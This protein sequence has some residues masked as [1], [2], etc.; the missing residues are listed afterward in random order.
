MKKAGRRRSTISSASWRRELR[1]PGRFP[2]ARYPATLLRWHRD[3]VRRKW[4]LRVLAL[5]LPLDVT[6]WLWGKDSR[7]GRDWKPR[8]PLPGPLSQREEVDG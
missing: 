3:L 7:D 5:L 1:S 6:A 8:E 2:C 4:T